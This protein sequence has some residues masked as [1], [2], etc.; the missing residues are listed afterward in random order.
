MSVKV[1]GKLRR[2]PATPGPNPIDH[3]HAFRKLPS[4]ELLTAPPPNIKIVD[5][6]ATV[7]LHE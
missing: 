5:H 2:S 3:V 7:E 6:A 4:A 1:G